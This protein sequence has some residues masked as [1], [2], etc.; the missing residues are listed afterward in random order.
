[1]G[2]VGGLY[3]LRALQFDRSRAQVVEQPDALSK[4]N[5]YQVYVYLVKK[6]RPNALLHDAG[7]GHGDV[8]LARIADGD[9]A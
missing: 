1:M 8:L 5:G 4:Q 3:H 2:Y 7:G 9:P 6:F